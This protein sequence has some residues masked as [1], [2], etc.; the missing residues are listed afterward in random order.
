[1]CKN[2]EPIKMPVRVWTRGGARNHVL[3]GYRS[4]HGRANF[5][6]ERTCPGMSDDTAMS[7]AKMAEPIEMPFG[8]WT[9]VGPR[10][11]MRWRST[12]GCDQA[13]AGSY[14]SICV[15]MVR[16]FVHGAGFAAAQ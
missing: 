15:D 5:L 16:E 10:K 9:L 14:G 3:M 8:L 6:P 2:A 7:C 11:C 4:P 1:M 12:L 13:Y